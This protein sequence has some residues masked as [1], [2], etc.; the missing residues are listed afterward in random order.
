MIARLM[1]QHQQATAQLDQKIA[2][3]DARMKTGYDLLDAV[4]D[5]W[6]K[7]EAAEAVT[8]KVA[9]A[10]KEITL[11]DALAKALAPDGIPSQLIGEAISPVNDL[12][13]V[14]SGH[15]FPGRNLALPEDLNI[16]LS[17]SPYATLS[18]STKFRV[19]VAFQYGLAKL[20]G[21]RLLMIDEADILDPSNRTALIDFLLEIQP[22]FDTIIIFATSQEAK[23]SPIP[24]IKI[25]WLESGRIGPVETDDAAHDQAA[26]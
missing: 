10:E 26:G 6:R 11:Y 2:V 1:V 5:F 17:G 9:Q 13:E 21:A 15:L 20:A 4:R 25:W 18:K 19:G 14:A 16:E 23:P 8:A 3:L 22:D 7:K 24:E 12:L